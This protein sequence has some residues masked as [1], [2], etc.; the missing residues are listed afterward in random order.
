MSGVVIAMAVAQRPDVG[1]HAWVALQYLLGFRSL[2]YEV[3]FVDQLDPQMCR[4]AAGRPCPPQDSINVAYLAETM[5]RFGLAD[6]WAV[7]TGEGQTLGI[8]RDELGTRLDSA[9]LINVMG[10]LADADLLGRA[11]TRVFLDIDPGFPQMWRALDLHDGFSGHDRFATVGLN[12]NGPACTV[13]DCGLEWVTTLPPVAL[14]HWPPAPDGRRFTSVATWRGPFGP[15]E[16]GGRTYGLRVHEFRGLLELPARTDAE[17]EL[18]L[19]IDPEDGPD[20]RELV[21]QGWKL[22]DPVTAAGDPIAYRDFIAGSAAELMV[23]KNMYVESR[24]GWFSDRS[25]CYLASGKPVLAQ[26][27]GFSAFVP[28]GEGLISFATLQDASAGV[29]EIRSDYGRHAA[30]ARALAEE[31]LDARRVLGRLIDELGSP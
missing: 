8:G 25:A 12:L 27:T 19:K 31:H 11:R 23:A 1:G 6:S 17:F 9:L 14:D 20:I 24:G 3:T 10:Y 4:D 15:I 7:L 21:Q 26:D 28:T 18:A 13:P 29:D 16:Y 22:T 5:T 30:A 2:G